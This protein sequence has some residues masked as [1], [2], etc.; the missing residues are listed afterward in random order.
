MASY[1]NF[2]F[3]VNG[4]E[5]F[6]ERVR[7]VLLN[8]V[9]SSHAKPKLTDNGNEIILNYNGY[10]FHFTFI[11]DDYV[12]EESAEI[13]NSFAR[14][15]ADKHKIAHCK[16]RVEFYGDDDFFMHHFNESLFLLDAIKEAEQVVIFDYQ[17]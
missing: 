2:I 8:Y 17:S 16:S 9:N 3:P 11:S 10:E 7:S 13:A 12:A 5:G 15:R 6:F 14:H 1:T 4:D